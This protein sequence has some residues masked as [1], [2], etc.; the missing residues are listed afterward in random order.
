MV[1][2]RRRKRDLESWVRFVDL[3]QNFDGVTDGGN[4]DVVELMKDGLQLVFRSD[5]VL[6]RQSK[7]GVQPRV[8]EDPENIGG[9]TQ[10]NGDARLAQFLSIQDHSAHSIKHPTHAYTTTP[11]HQLFNEHTWHRYRGDRP[12]TPDTSDMSSDLKSHFEDTP[13]VIRAIRAVHNKDPEA[14]MCRDQ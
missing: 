9:L 11:V 1:L 3:E 14:L 7:G 13:S 10:T 8:G 6:A 2:Q 12:G 5:Q 4:V